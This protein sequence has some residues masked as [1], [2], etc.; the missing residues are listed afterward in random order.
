[1]DFVEWYGKEITETRN[2][3]YILC[4]IY[5]IIKLYMTQADGS[6]TQPA[7]NYIVNY[8]AQADWFMLILQPMSLLLNI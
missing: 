8:M 3:I 6:L 7:D 4:F 2:L 5:Q 1:M